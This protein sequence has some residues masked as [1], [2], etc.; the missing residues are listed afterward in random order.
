MNLEEI[1]VAIIGLGYVGLPLA[2]ELAQQRPVIGFDID[3]DRVSDLTQGI[4]CTKEVDSQKLLSATNLKLTS[5]ISVIGSANFYIICVPTPLTAENEPDLSILRKATEMVGSVLNHGDVVVFE[6]TVYPG[7]TEEECVPILE[8]TSGLLFNVNFFC[9]Y[10]PERVNPGDKTRGIPNVKKIT[11]GS[12]PEIASLVDELYRTI[13]LAGTVKVSSMQVAE[14]AKVIENV[15]RDLNIALVN[16]LSMIFKQMNLDT[17]EVLEAAATKWNFILF[18]PGLVGGHC[19]G[20]DPY[21]L[22]YKA[23]AIGLDTN[24]IA[25]GR[26]VNSSMGSF[27]ASSLLN[28]LKRRSI[29]SEGAKVLIMG[30]SFKENCPDIRNSG[31]LSLLNILRDVGCLVDLYDPLVNEQEAKRLFGTHLIH[32]IEINYYEVIIIAVGHDEFKRLGID[33]IRSFGREGNIVFDLKGL[34]PTV[35]TDFRL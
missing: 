32:C 33:K 22:T 23:R 2:V 34:F 5:D 19:I 26:E 1:D 18:Y 4:D 6:S 35:D 20:V 25:A 3:L 14:A 7:C 29:A 30:I 31:V 17:R 15:Q 16:E 11:S 9:G 10:S 8:Q 28:C 12:T 27:I 21:Y 13:V 24:V